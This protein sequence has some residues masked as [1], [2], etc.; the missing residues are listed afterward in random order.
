M[1]EQHI[2]TGAGVTVAGIRVPIEQSSQFGVIETAEDGI[3]IER[4][5]EKPKTAKGL[6]GRAGP[7]LRLDGQLRV[8]DPDAHRRGRRR[9]PRRGLQPRPRRRH[10][11][12]ARRDRRRRTSTTS[13][14]TR[15]PAHP[16]ASAA[17][18][19]TS[20]RSTPTT[21]RTW[22]SSRR[23]RSSTSTT[24]SGRSTAGP[25]RCRRRSSS[26]RR[27]G[28]RGRRSARWSAPA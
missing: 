6:P 10:H 5:R 28:A 27:R 20:G 18:G 2:A 23:S 12:H 7:D 21:T 4:F 22:T 3:T 9:R 13:P 19:E 26:S 16:S 1:V 15:C 14:P 17:T 8:H 25:S 11:P 24:R